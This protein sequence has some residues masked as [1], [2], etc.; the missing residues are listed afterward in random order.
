[1]KIGQFDSDAA[2]L[3]QR[4]QINE[5][6]SSADL[7]EWIF[8][9]LGLQAGLKV[10]DLGCGTGKQS[11]PAARIVGDDG[12]VTAVDISEE[13]LEELRKQAANAGLSHRITTL[14]VGL[15]DFGEM[16]GAS[17]FDRVISSYSLYYA[18]DPKAVVQEISERLRLGG[19][20]FICGPSKDN[21]AELRGFRA[22]LKSKEPEALNIPPTI[23]EDD[24][25]VWVRSL[26]GEVTPSRLENRLT[27]DSPS[28]LYRYWSSHNLYDA[29]LDG[30][31]KAAADRHFRTYGEFHNVKRVIGIRAVKQEP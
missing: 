20:M 26:F 9:Q 21:N 18:R 24:L 7:N 31:F 15:D 29:G 27:F 10:L 17:T 25:P 13:A 19:V 16:I 12:H 28:A 30:D 5:R 8:A 22:A 1:M 4:L 2:A 11:L 14:H 3:K 23:M 6:Y